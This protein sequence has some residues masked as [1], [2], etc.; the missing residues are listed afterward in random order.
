MVWGTV[1]YNYIFKLDTVSSQLSKE[2]Y[3]IYVNT[4]GWG[5]F[6]RFKKEVVDNTQI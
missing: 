3:N 6:K 4:K 1:I 2:F 5:I